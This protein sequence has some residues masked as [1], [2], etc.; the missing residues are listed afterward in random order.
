MSTIE[1]IEGIFDLF[2]EPKIVVIVIIFTL[3]GLYFK[4]IRGDV[5]FF[6]FCYAIIYGFL[7]P[8]IN[9]GVYLPILIKLQRNLDSKAYI[10]YKKEVLKIESRR[11]KKRY[12]FYTLVRAKRLNQLY[13]DIDQF[14]KENNEPSYTIQ[15][16][17]E[18]V[19]LS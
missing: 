16:L 14:L 18:K 7:C 1:I 9:Y 17:K 10:D 12:S 6:F 13:K 4:K 5:I 15:E 3:V 11:N 2:I 19:R 8:R